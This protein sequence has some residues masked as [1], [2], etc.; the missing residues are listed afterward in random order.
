MLGVSF[1]FVFQGY[2]IWFWFLG[3]RVCV[4]FLFSFFLGFSFFCCFLL[5]CWCGIFFKD[6]KARGR[7][8]NSGRKAESQIVND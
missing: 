6:L 2:G 1:G 4:W 3:G 8:E 7:V 5:G